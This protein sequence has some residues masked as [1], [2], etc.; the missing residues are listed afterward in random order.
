MKQAVLVV[1]GDSSCR[2]RSQP[3]RVSPCSITGFEVCL[4]GCG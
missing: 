4:R 3:T 1:D 2:T